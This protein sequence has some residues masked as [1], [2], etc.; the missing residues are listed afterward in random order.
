[1]PSI[2]VS[3]AF[4]D[5]PA[6]RAALRAVDLADARVLLALARAALP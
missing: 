1:M 4:A 5:V 2:R 6:V 3:A